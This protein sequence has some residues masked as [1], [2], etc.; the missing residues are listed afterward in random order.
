[1][2]DRLDR[3]AVAVGG[4]VVVVLVGDHQEHERGDGTGEQCCD[5]AEHEPDE[6]VPA[7]GRVRDVATELRQGVLGESGD[8]R[9]IGLEVQVLDVFCRWRRVE[10]CLVGHG[11]RV[12]QQPPP[13][14]RRPRAERPSRDRRAGGWRTATTSD[15]GRLRWRRASGPRR[16]PLG[17]RG[18]ASR[19]PLSWSRWRRFDPVIARR[20][21]PG[22][23]THWPTPTVTGPGRRSSGRSSSP[24]D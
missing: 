3:R 10:G 21:P 5:E 15:H 9:L 18:R 16:A 1:M 8:V 6:P 23:S 12:P 14:T 7:A 20:P 4:A 22:W 13:R 19:T 2:I 24:L 17:L 11:D